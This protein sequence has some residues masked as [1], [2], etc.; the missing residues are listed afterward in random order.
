[1]KRKSDREFDI[2]MRGVNAMLDEFPGMISKI[3]TDELMNKW[4]FTAVENGGWVSIG[5]VDRLTRVA[6]RREQNRIIAEIEK[7]LPVSVSAVEAY[8][9]MMMRIR[10]PEKELNT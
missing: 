4:G 6:T 5:D 10:Y 9:D 8:R 3:R 1:M 2:F 7:P